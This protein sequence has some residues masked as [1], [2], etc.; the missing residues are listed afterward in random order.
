MNSA[1]AAQLLEINR[2][3]YLEHGT[4]FADTR[5]RIQPGV[6]RVL[7]SLRTHD[8]ILDLGC[9]SGAFAQALSQN[10]HRGHYLGLDFSAPAVERASRGRYEFPASFLEADLTAPDE[11]QTLIEA[12]TGD[13]TRQGWAVIVAFAVLHHIPDRRLRL[14]LLEQARGWM[15]ADGT[16]ILSNWQ[17][18]ANS[19]VRSRIRPWSTAGLNEKDVD[20]GDYLVEWRR[21][22]MGIRYVHEFGEGELAELAEASGFKLEGSFVSDGADHRSGLYQIWRPA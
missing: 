10:G 14:G 3:F 17:F 2:R 15:R 6:R 22:G 11:L 9:G 13:E 5:Q 1:R 8:T 12:S 16:F 19:R 21:G 7:Q 20:P 18:T 4:D